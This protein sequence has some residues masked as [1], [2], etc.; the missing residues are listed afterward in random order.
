MNAI[1]L[2]IVLGFLF[3]LAKKALPKEYQ[4]KGYYGWICFGILSVTAAFGF[5]GGLWGSL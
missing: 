4:L 5:I 3:L 2:P 1:A